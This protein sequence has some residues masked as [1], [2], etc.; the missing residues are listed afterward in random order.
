MNG[1]TRRQINALLLGLPAASSALSTSAWAIPSTPAVDRDT[2]VL[3]LEKEVQN[4]DALITATGDSLRYAWQMYDTLYGFDSRGNIEP[5]MASSYQ[6]SD[7]GL[8]YTYKLRPGILFHNGDPF[9]SEDV[10]FTMERTLDPA[11]KSTRRPL[12]APIV[13]SVETPD[14]QTVI[15]RLKQPDGAFLNKVAGFLFIGPKRYIA[16]L[17]NAFA[18]KPIGTGPYKLVR[19]EVG[20]ALELE[21]FDGFYGTKPGIRR[22]I[23]KIIPEA[24]TRVNA[25]L[26][27]EVDLAVQVPLNEKERLQG[28]TG[29]KVIVNPVSSPL[30]VR[31]YCNDES[32]PTSKRDVRLALNYGLDSSAIIKSIYHGVGRPLATFIS[33]YYP[34]GSDPDLKPFAYDPAKAKALLAKAGYPKGFE[35]KL[36]SAN[37]HPKEL[38]EAI[39]AY[40]GQIGVK[41]EIQRIDYAAWSRLNNTHKSGPMTISQFTN[42]IYDPISAVA[43]SFA[44][45]GTWSDYYNPEVEQLIDQLN[46]T[47]G[48]ENRGRLFRKAGQILHDDAAVVFITELFYVF[49]HKA[50][51][52]WEIQQGSGFLNFRNVAWQ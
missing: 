15:F 43:G 20:Q 47:V 26:T 13:A 17:P 25:L 42:A 1:I 39:A 37:D 33:S 19:H 32:L 50:S 8:A 4:L 44:K 52:A 28:E 3:A 2:L 24:S 5:R 36:Y 40:W 38:A 45:E 21:R 46:G 7:D 49:A 48:A 9:T 23:M 14:P 10:A 11:A 41:T 35:T 6:V 16:S 18:L 12:F 29:L 27:G 51:L 31:L 22:L 30:Y 34:Y